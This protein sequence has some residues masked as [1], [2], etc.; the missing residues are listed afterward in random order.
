[1]K[2][3]LITFETAKLAKK[4]GYI[5]EATWNTRLVYNLIDGAVFAVQQRTPENA[6]EKCEQSLLQRWL[7]EVHNCIVEV[8]F[9]KLEDLNKLDW[10]CTVDYYKPDFSNLTDEADYISDY[11]DTYEQALE[12]G[13]YEA[14]KLI[15]TE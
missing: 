14:L 5:S 10:I 8:T 11:Y 13:L 3:E 15:K 4:K 9:E 7:R 12:A 6:C 1:M 2:N